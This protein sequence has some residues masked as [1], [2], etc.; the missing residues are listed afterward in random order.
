M[1]FGFS[2]A[3]WR[4]WRPGGVHWGFWGPILLVSQGRGGSPRGP[5]QK[6]FP[7]SLWSE[8]W[9]GEEGMD[10]C[11]FPTWAEMSYL[12]I[13]VQKKTGQE[14]WGRP[15]HSEVQGWSLSDYLAPKT[16]GNKLTEHRPP[17][18]ID[19]LATMFIFSHRLLLSHIS[20]LNVNFITFKHLISGLPYVNSSNRKCTQW[21]FLSK[22]ICYNFVYWKYLLR[23]FV[24][25][26]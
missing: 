12:S 13:L 5:G 14:Q 1:S 7:C 3:E 9:L 19:P 22:Q 4:Q 17:S 11:H 26:S 2:C 23:P 10:K 25:G 20:L 18:G 6:G 21:Y 24:H 16:Q 8:S 15:G